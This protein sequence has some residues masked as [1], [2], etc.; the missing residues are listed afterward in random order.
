MLL[1][2]YAT[3]V[4][5]ILKDIRIYAS[6][7]L[8]IKMGERVLDICCGTGD[9][10]FYYSQKG[11]MAT[12]VDQ[13]S[14]MIKISEKNNK[15]RGL[16]DVTFHLASATELPFSDGYFDHASI[17]L[18]LH[19][20]ERDERDKAIAEMKRVVKKGGILMFI[21]FKVPLPNNCIAYF[22]KTVEFVAGRDNY[23]CFK[24]YLAQGG[25]CQILKENKLNPQLE[26]L[27]KL[28]NLQIIKS[29]N[30]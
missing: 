4:D 6:D 5:P 18:G 16:N 30:I 7:F 12:G 24:D 19:E 26:T 17:S 2:N 28:G 27:L 8:G 15:K 13:N 23:R 22:I 14:K 25:L 9:Q 3:L 1:L 20:M 11:A 29:N 10:V 21:D